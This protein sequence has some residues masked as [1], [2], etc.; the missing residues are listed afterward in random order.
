ML[1]HFVFIEA[2]K[3][4]FG[5]VLFARFKFVDSASVGSNGGALHMSLVAEV[6]LRLA[7]SYPRVSDPCL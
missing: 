3:V 2:G 6:A 7:P 1:T 5:P 4:V